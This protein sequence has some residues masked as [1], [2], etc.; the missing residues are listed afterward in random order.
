MLVPLGFPHC[1]VVSLRTLP[2][3]LEDKKEGG[4]GER[5]KER[6]R[7]GGSGE[8]EGEGEKERERWGWGGVGRGRGREK[9]NECMDRENEQVKLQ[10]PES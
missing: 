6:E 1:T 2:Y 4:R 8:G 7:G 3:I 5:E 10:L 9:A